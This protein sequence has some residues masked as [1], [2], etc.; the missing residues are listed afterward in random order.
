VRRQQVAAVLALP[1]LFAAASACSG[2]STH[3]RT[4]RASAESIVSPPLVNPAQQA[5]GAVRGSATVTVSNS[6][7]RF[8]LSTP[9]NVTNDLAVDNSGKLVVEL[10]MRGNGGDVFSIAG[11]ARLGSVT[12]DTVAVVIPQAGVLVDTS[13]GNSCAVHF[14]Q[15]SQTRAGGTAR[16]EGQVSGQP[17][18]VNVSFAVATT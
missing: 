15:A 9:S 10:S 12:N 7:R 11:T 14:S 18:T 8:A 5:I 16:C 17:V 2:G 1:L 4:P 13:S 3:H 6:Q